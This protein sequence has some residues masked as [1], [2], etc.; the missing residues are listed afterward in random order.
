MAQVMYG[1]G[2][3]LAEMLRLRVKDVE[4]ERNQII[5][6]AGKGNK[7]RVT[8]L[9]EFVKPR[10]KEHLQRV[11]IYHEKDRK[12]DVPGVE[13]PYLQRDGSGSIPGTNV[14]P[15]ASLTFSSAGLPVSSST[16]T[17]VA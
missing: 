7:D 9:A 1:S 14:G 16:T 17:T 5:V 11:R 4:L 3:R 6:R 12:N 10:L 15:A 13:L 8:L 2:L